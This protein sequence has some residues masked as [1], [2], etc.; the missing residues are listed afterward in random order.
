M[1]TISKEEYAELLRRDYELSCLEDGGVDNWD[2]YGESFNNDE[3]REVQEYTI[4]EIIK[5]LGGRD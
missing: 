1:I 2:W 3:W 4:D 5:E